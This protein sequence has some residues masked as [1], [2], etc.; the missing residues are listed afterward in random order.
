MPPILV[1]G[2]DV[3]PVMG[4]TVPIGILVTPGG[5]GTGGNPT[6]PEGMLVGETAMI[7]YNGEGVMG[8]GHG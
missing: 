3:K 4:T 8:G 6:V 1:T 5:M 2:G 7:M